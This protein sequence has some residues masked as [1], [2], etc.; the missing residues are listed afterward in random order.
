[1]VDFTWISGICR[2]VEAPRL[3]RALLSNSQCLYK[4]PYKSLYSRTVARTEGNYLGMG[5]SFS[6]ANVSHS[7]CQLWRLQNLYTFCVLLL[8]H[9]LPLALIRPFSFILPLCIALC[10][11][12][13]STQCTQFSWDKIKTQS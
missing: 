13:C 5:L 11:Q 4:S 9:S 1:M 8:Y 12:L 10:L 6:L 2:A 7:L 3:S